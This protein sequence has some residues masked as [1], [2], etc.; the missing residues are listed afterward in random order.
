[1]TIRDLVLSDDPKVAIH[2][3]RL[4]WREL[5]SAINDSSGLYMPVLTNVTNISAS[6]P[7]QCQCERVGDVVTVS[8]RVDVDAVAAT[9]TQLGIS[10][11][12]TS[13]FAND[14][15]CAGVASSLSGQA[16]AIIADTTNNRA[17]MQWVATDL[18]NAAMYFSFSYRIRK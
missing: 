3:L 1:M 15:E 5:V 14:Y 4:Q 16:A 10:L 13:I 17:Q 18:T 9:S 12:E 11:P 6:T 7:Y 8:G 2:D